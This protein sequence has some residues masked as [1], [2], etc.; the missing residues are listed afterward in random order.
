MVKGVLLTSI[1]QQL[2]TFGQNEGIPR[3][4]GLASAD[5]KINGQRESPTTMR[6]IKGMVKDIAPKNVSN[7]MSM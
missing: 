5:S 3:K 7:P 1:C 6:I 4:M 2:E